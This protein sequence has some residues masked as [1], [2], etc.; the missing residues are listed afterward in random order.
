ML[1]FGH[2]YKKRP[3]MRGTHAGGTGEEDRQ[4]CCSK[5]AASSSPLSVPRVAACIQAEYKVEQDQL[6]AW[7]DSGKITCVVTFSTFL[8]GFACAFL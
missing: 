6:A 5:S 4:T 7:L 3:C 1:H 8:A 2:G